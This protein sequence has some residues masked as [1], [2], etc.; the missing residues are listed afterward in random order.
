MSSLATARS[1]W[2]RTFS[3]RRRVTTSR[4]SG[5]PPEKMTMVVGVQLFLTH[6]F[7]GSQSESFTSV[8]EEMSSGRYTIGGDVS[9]GC[10]RMVND[11]VIDL[12]NR[13]PI[14]TKVIVL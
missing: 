13:A 6:T 11:D 4:T 3:T 14:G 2:L 10:I 1:P 5:M 9:S 7:F 12:Y 8:Y